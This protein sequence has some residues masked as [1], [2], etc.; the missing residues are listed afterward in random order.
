MSPQTPPMTFEEWS[1]RASFVPI[2]TI[3]VRYIFSTCERSPNK[4]RKKQTPDSRT[5]L[6]H[7]PNMIPGTDALPQPP[8][9]AFNPVMESCALK[10][11]IG[12]FGGWG[13][14]IL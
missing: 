12:T 11:G 8:Y 6:N 1:R 7:I 5:Q 10:A 2:P 14:G 4:F 13:M 9:D 3:R